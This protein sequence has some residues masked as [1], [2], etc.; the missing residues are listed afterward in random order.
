MHNQRTNQPTDTQEYRIASAVTTQYHLIFARIGLNQSVRDGTCT[1]ISLHRRI[2][3]INIFKS[4]LS[5]FKLWL[6]WLLLF[7]A[8]DFFARGGRLGGERENGQFALEK[9]T[10]TFGDGKIGETVASDSAM[11]Q[12]TTTTAAAKG[13]ATTTATTMNRSRSEEP[14]DEGKKSEKKVKETDDQNEK[15]STSI[16]GVRSNVKV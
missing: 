4:P 16:K 5:R 7:S 8:R 6:L 15:K 2:L 10:K 1:L 9:R 11:V 12:T 13:A 14:K 3:L